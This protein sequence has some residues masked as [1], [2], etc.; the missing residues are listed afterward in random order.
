MKMKIDKKELI[1]KQRRTWQIKPYTRVM[2]DHKAYDRKSFKQETKQ[3]IEEN[4][5]E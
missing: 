4:K 5:D 2:D 1:K 3:F